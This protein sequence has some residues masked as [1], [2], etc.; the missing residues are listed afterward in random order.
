MCFQF[1]APD[2]N[3][4]LQFRKARIVPS[5]PEELKQNRT[6]Q[7]RE[8]HIKSKV[9]AKILQKLNKKGE[10]ETPLQKQKRS[11]YP[12]LCWS[13]IYLTLVKTHPWVV[14]WFFDSPLESGWSN[15]AESWA[16][17]I[18]PG[19]HRRPTPP[20][21]GGVLWTWGDLLG[22]WEGGSTF[23]RRKVS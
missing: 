3:F 12:L 21:G 14:G 10:K 19:T 4:V 1:D 8:K 18:Q 2:F 7:K 16:S 11:F 13:L 5:F 23:W 22:T 6:E 15:P 17:E 9:K 20:G